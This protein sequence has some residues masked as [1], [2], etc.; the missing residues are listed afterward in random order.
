M[1]FTGHCLQFTGKRMFLITTADE[2][3]WKRGEKILFLGEWCKLYSRKE[4]WEKLDYDVLP[5]HWDNR[6]KLFEDFNYLTGIYERCLVKLANR[7]NNINCVEHSVR[8]WRIIIGPWLHYFIAILFDRYVSLKKA[9][10]SYEI[11][12]TWIADTELWEWVP[13]DMLC[14]HRYFCGDAYNY[15]LYSKIIRQLELVP[16]KIVDSD[17]VPH[18]KSNIATAIKASFFQHNIKSIVKTILSRISQFRN[19]SF[20]FIASYLGQY[21]QARLEI[22]LGQL[23][24][25]FGEINLPDVE[26]D[27]KLRRSLSIKEANSEF[28]SLLEKFIPEQMPAAYVENYRKIREIAHSCYPKKPKVIFTASAYSSNE[29]FKCWSADQVE[30]GAKLVIGQHGGHYGTGLW[31]WTEEHQIKISDQYI[32]WGWKVPNEPKVQSLPAGKLIHIKRYLLP[33]SQGHILWVWCGFPRYSYWMYSVPV[34]SQFLNHLE[35]QIDFAKKL[36]HDARRLLLLRY[37]PHDY[38][39]GESD[40]MRELNLGIHDYYGKQTMEDQL[41]QSRLFVGTH[42]TTTYLETF[43]SDFPTILFWN[44]DHWELRP[45]AKIFFDELRTAEIL[46][47]TPASAA[48]KVNEIY[49]DPIKWWKTP[50]VQNAK[51]RFCEQYAKSSPKWI[52]D[53]KAK[54]IEIALDNV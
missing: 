40:K 46:H 1:F 49:R 36:S 42:N 53:W 21:E 37:Y 10:E 16:Y 54:L 38:G 19:P 33:N 4:E 18:I 25:S 47:D 17:I 28:E 7:L 20:F 29:G 27:P 3:T 43:V 32:T 11:T 35:D 52:K 26:V 5:Y 2:Q 34:A 22:A 23:P 41:N 6:K 44:P 45:S 48:Q 24:T 14:F 50:K 15:V 51:N 39:W 13:Q 31:N 30:H 9:S 12:N 8:Y